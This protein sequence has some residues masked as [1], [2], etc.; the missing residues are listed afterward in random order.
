MRLVSEHAL[1]ITT[2]E[3]MQP[4]SH[5]VPPSGPLPQT[6]LG[7]DPHHDHAIQELRVLMLGFHSSLH[8]E[9]L[10]M[11]RALMRVEGELSQIQRRLG[12]DHF[13]Y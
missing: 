9:M 5:E 7:E 13:P 6:I 2:A 1:K 10:E 11:K 12:M 4:A 3:T 8:R